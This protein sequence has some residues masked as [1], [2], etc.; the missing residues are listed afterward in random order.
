MV[1]DGLSRLMGQKNKRDLK[2]L[3][4][5]AEPFIFTEML[6]NRFPDAD[7]VGVGYG[8]GGEESHD[9]RGKEVMVHHYNVEQDSWPFKND[10]FDSVLMMAILEHLFDPV[11]ALLR[12]RRVLNRQ[13]RC[14]IT[15]PNAVRLTRRVKTL[16]GQNPFDGYPLETRYNRH[17]HEFTYEELEDLLPR[18]GLL[19][20]R[21]EMLTERRN[22]GLAKIIEYATATH[23]SIRDQIYAEVKKSSLEGGLPQVYRQGITEDREAHPMLEE[24]E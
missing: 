16:F 15:T 11:A 4:V 17:Q 23:P 1:I 3:E 10:E 8:D 13:G 7:I 12:A 2:I 18:V 24:Y 22:P 5:G 9:I 21:I 6:V 14:F 20:A 19:P